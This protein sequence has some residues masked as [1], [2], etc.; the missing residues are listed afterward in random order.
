MK[1][2]K[3]T[4]EKKH[5]RRGKWCARVGGGHRGGTTNAEKVYLRDPGKKGKNNK[6]NKVP[7]K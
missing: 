6:K 3:Q 7:V 2:S 1:Y 4:H 5:Q